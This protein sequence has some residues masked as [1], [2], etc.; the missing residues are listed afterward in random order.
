MRPAVSR[1]KNPFE[2]SCGPDGTMNRSPSPC[3][4]PERHR[5]LA[6]VGVLAEL[7]DELGL[8]LALQEEVVT[9]DGDP[10][11]LR[12]CLVRAGVVGE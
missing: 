6:V 1:V 5:W 2:P 3:S 8:R 9:L 11:D 4:M 7:G 10:H 12:D